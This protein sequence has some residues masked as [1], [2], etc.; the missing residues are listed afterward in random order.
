MNYESVY[1]FIENY[2]AFY[3]MHDLI[4]SPETC[5]L[6]EATDLFGKL[7]N[8]LLRYTERVTKEEIEIIESEYPQFGGMGVIQSKLIGQ[9]HILRHQQKEQRGD[10]D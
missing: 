9:S 5:D 1:E 2:H 10:F 8:G 7:V 4:Y 3:K 6:V